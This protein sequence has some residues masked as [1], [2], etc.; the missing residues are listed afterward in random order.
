MADPTAVTAPSPM[1]GAVLPLSAATDPEEPTAPRRRRTTD[2]AEPGAPAWVMTWPEDGIATDL[3]GVLFLIVAM[4]ALDLPDAF[5]DSLGLASEAGAWGTLDLLGRA[6]LAPFARPADIADPLWPVLASLAGRRA[7]S[8]PRLAARTGPTFQVPLAWPAAV[9]DDDAGAFAWGAAGGRVRLWSEQSGGY[10]LVD[11]PL[12]PASTGK[13]AVF[14]ALSRYGLEAGCRHRAFASA[15]LASVRGP[16]VRGLSRD[17]IFWLRRVVP[18]VRLRLH[19]ALGS[20]ADGVDPVA[21]LFRRRARLYVTSTHVD[22]AMSLDEVSLPARLAGLD[23]DP[24]WLPEFG[25]VIKF[26]YEA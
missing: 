12:D 6:L 25:R 1:M 13:E 5:E 26:H 23:R 11:R 3:G 2:R 14:S 17:L 22:L 24:G 4:C 21:H 8:S 7:T 10:L 15:P 18:F 9:G 19:R 16:L 20:P